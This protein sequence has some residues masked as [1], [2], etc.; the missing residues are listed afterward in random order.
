M[1]SDEQT[2]LLQQILEVQKEQLAFSKQNSQEF[3][4]M[5]QAAIEGQKKGLRMSRFALLVLILAVGLLVGSIFLNSGIE[6][7]PDG[8]K[9]AK[10]FNQI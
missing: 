6:E 4:A 3:K 8:E 2:H 1:N 7:K 10:G 5:Q 9:P